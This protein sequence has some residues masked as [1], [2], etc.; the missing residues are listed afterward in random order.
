MSAPFVV[1]L[2]GSRDWASEAAVWA[3]LDNVVD[4]HPGRTLV[5]RHGACSTGAD[6]HCAAWCGRAAS[7]GR[8]VTEEPFPADWSLH[9]RRA[10]PI[11]NWAMVQ[12]GA[13]LVLAFV[14]PGPSRGTRGTVA[15]ACRVGIPVRLFEVGEVR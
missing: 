9:G 10:G 11:R 2:T 5:V 15:L 8:A 13:D 12:A 6:A 7:A 4:E 1:L 14:S 3:A